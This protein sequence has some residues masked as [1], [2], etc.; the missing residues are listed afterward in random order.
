MTERSVLVTRPW[1]RSA[2]RNENDTILFIF[3]WPEKIVKFCEERGVR[4]YDLKKE[5]ANRKQLE[6][7]LRAHA[8]WL[9]ALNGHGGPAYV[10]G[11]NR[12]PIAD[13]NNAHLFSGKIVHALSCDSA[14]VFGEECV[15]KGALT[16][17]GYKERFTWVY[18]WNMLAHPFDDYMS[19][20][21]FEAAIKA[22]TA[23]IEGD[24]VDKAKERSQ[25]KYEEAIKYH[26]IHYSLESNAIIMTLLHDMK[27][28]VVI[29]RE[30]VSV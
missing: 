16:F 25:Q 30:G 20:D 27:N 17:I 21:N 5:K 24:S 1:Y 6:D 9:V 29:K 10:C 12:Q 19:R 2:D 11:H 4:C 13:V 7:F 26:R 15:K 14:Q 18:D 8:P 3:H 23:L 28:Q 22:V